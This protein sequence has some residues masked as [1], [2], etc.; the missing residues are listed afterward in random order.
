MRLYR[1]ADV[2]GNTTTVSL[3]QRAVKTNKLKNFIILSGMLG[4]GKS[5]CAE[6]IGLVLT[7]ENPS[8][9]EPCLQCDVCK[10]NI[11]ALQTSG[12]SNVLVKKNVSL[13]KEKGDIKKLISEIFVL[14]GTTGNQV[15]II[16]EAH[17]ISPSDQTPL[18]EEIDRLSENTYVVICTTRPHKLLPE[19][20]SRAISYEFKRI[21]KSDAK[22]LFDRTIRKLGITRVSK[23]TEAMIYRYAKGVPRDIVKLIQFVKDNH[24][25]ES[26]MRDFLGFIS[27]E[28]FIELFKSMKEGLREMSANLNSLLSNYSI[29]S[30]VAQLKTFVVNC[31]FLLDGGESE[32]F[33]KEEAAEISQLFPEDVCMS[34][35]LIAEKMD[36]N[37][38]SES[39]LALNLIKMSRVFNQKSKASLLSDNNKQ[40][41]QQSIE[42]DDAYYQEQ[43][44]RGKQEVNSLRPVSVESLNKFN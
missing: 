15:Y 9:G 41:S 4:T 22:L 6:I 19:L 31:V 28:V 1:F 26:E 8:E 39:D 32:E 23:S 3:L 10:T 33:T 30:I 40:A 37:S 34:I 21:T 44:I 20:R 18:L 43:A 13:M 12:A 27:S 29:E 38:M 5:T 25:T 24:P 16:E 7:C 35:A 11:K 17:E 42:A 2:V 36:F 14:Q